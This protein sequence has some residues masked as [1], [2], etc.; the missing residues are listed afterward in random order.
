M[1]RGMTSSARCRHVKLY[2]PCCAGGEVSCPFRQRCRES[3]K[4]FRKFRRK[5]FLCHRPPSTPGRRR[6]FAA[7]SGKSAD[8]SAGGRSQGH[9]TSGYLLGQLGVGLLHRDRLLGF[10]LRSLGVRGDLAGGFARN[11]L[12]ETF[13]RFRCKV[14][15]ASSP[16]CTV[17]TLAGQFA[18]RVLLRDDPLPRPGTDRRPLTGRQI[19]ALEVHREDVSV[20]R[21]LPRHI[22]RPRARCPTFIQARSLRSN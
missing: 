7:L 18:L 16:R 6:L 10:V 20:N 12:R 9:R 14:F 13:Q 2:P 15:P 22:P 4:P 1:P 11:P 3:L 21:D 8:G 17:R 5:G 19:P